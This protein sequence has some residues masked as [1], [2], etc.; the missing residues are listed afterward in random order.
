[1]RRAVERGGRQFPAL[2]ETLEK[3]EDRFLKEDRVMAILSV[4][5]GTLAALGIYG[6]LG[7]AVTRRT[8]EIG[9]R[10]AVGQP[11]QVWCG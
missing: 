5:L 6:V 3:H 10:V 1:M 4:F 8:A 2:I 11:N 9:V 7:H